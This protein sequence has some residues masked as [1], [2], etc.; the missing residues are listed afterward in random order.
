MIPSPFM[1]L[2]LVNCGVIYFSFFIFYFLCERGDCIWRISFQDIQFLCKMLWWYINAKASKQSGCCNRAT[3]IASTRNEGATLPILPRSTKCKPLNPSKI[4]HYCL[5]V[6]PYNLLHFVVLHNFHSP[7][8]TPT[9]L[10][11]RY[12]TYI[13]GPK[14]LGLG[15]HWWT[16]TFP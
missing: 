11:A 8:G 13:Y 9:G 1:F 2:P 5:L 4:P 14:Y 7:P 12:I 6:R 3:M 15:H 10:S 16:W